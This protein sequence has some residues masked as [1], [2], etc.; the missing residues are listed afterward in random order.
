MQKRTNWDEHLGRR[1]RL[2]DLH[3][4]LAVVRHGSMMR[5]ASQLNI[6]QPAISDAIATL[7]AAFGVRLLERSRKGVEPTS[8]G[9]LLL[10]YGRMAID[11]LRQGIKEIEFLADPT[12]G[13]LRILCT[14]TIANGVLVPIIQLLGH[15]YPRVRLDVAQFAT[16][17]YEFAELEQRKADLALVRLDPGFSRRSAPTLDALE[18]LDDQYCVVASRRSPLTR[19]GRIALSVLA[20]ARWVMPPLEGVAGG[21]SISTP[22]R[23]AF[24]DAGLQPPEFAITTFSV[25]LRTTMVAS[26]EYL[27]VLPKSVLKLHMDKICELPTDLAMPNWPLAI[28]TLKSRASNPAVG[29]FVECAKEIASPSRSAKKA[30]LTS[31]KR[32]SRSALSGAKRM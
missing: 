4:L 27:S 9:A 2:R 19:G 30:P 18:L 3:I 26:G 10:K 17:L 29:L 32:G 20:E 31:A 16:P 11:D 25:F 15:R 23:Q 1:V 13:E 21:A 5:A 24:A 8:Y 7:E 14:D 22:I 12:A 28:V 6:S